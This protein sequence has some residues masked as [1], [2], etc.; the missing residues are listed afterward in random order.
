MSSS[1]L[2]ASPSGPDDA[3]ILPFFTQRAWERSHMYSYAPLTQQP[4]EYDRERFRRTLLGL[5]RKGLTRFIIPYRDSFL[6]S[7]DLRAGLLAVAML[8]FL[9]CFLSCQLVLA[10]TGR[11]GS[12]LSVFHRKVPPLAEPSP[13]PLE[14]LGVWE[15]A[16]ARLLSIDPK[17][18]FSTIAANYPLIMCRLFVSLATSCSLLSLLRCVSS[19]FA[20]YTFG[21]Y[22]LDALICLSVFFGRLYFFFTYYSKDSTLDAWFSSLYLISPWI[23]VTFNLY[24]ATHIHSFLTQQQYILTRLALE[25]PRRYGPMYYMFAAD[26]IFPS[27]SLFTPVAPRRPSKPSPSTLHPALV[28]PAQPAPLRHSPAR[29]QQQLTEPENP[30]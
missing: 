20:Y 26:S 23:G 1:S 8:Q 10:A 27:S 18:W 22:I 14:I 13:L 2:E 21:F 4:T 17:D 3:E 19:S 15:M 24:I 28:L 11:F 7:I 25:W 6:K 29:R 9:V 5:S 30:V 12:P 16:Q